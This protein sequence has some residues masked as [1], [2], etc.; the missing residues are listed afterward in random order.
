[1]NPGDK[2]LAEVGIDCL[3]I[4]PFC[5]KVGLD[6]LMTVDQ[7]HETMATNDDE[8][9]HVVL[10]ALEVFTPDGVRI[11]MTAPH[12]QFGGQSPVKLIRTG[13]V[14]DVLRV[15]EQLATGSFA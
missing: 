14:D 10:A 12:T 5:K 3:G 11:W 2:T 13:R 1:M 4:L 6:P 9:I 7:L 8:L 15:I